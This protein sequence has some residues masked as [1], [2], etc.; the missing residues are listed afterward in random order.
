MAQSEDELREKTVLY[1]KL[2]CCRDS[3]SHCMQQYYD[4]N[5]LKLIRP[6]A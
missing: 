4:Y 3:R 2:S 1:K 5:R 6:T